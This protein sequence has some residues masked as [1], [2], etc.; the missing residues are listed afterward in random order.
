MQNSLT[1]DYLSSLVPEETI[2]PIIYEMHETLILS[3]HILNLTT[4]YKTFLPSVTRDLNEL[5]EKIRNLPS[6]SSFKRHLNSSLTASSKFF[7]DGKKLGQI[8]HTRL[9]MRCSSL[10]A[11]LFSKNIIDSPLCVYGSFEDAQHFS[12][13]FFFA[14]LYTL[15]DS[16]TRTG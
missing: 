8:Y 6:L 11:R 13:F 9:R 14:F 3:K 2:L 7:F 5:S 4:V 12:F 10:N 1:T 16:T 15:H